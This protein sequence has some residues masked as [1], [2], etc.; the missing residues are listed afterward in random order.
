M[1]DFGI[2]KARTQPPHT[3]AGRV[4]GKFGYN[5]REPVMGRPVGPPSD[6]FSAGVVAHELLTARPLFAGG[7]PYEILHR[8]PSISSPTCARPRP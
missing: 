5:S 1:I 2:A 7:T 8:I 4:K 3:E 6:V